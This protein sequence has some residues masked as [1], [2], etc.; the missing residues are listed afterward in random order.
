MEKINIS[1][2]LK[3]CPTGMELDCTI[4]DNVYFDE[5][6]PHMIKCFVKNDAY[7][8]I[9]FHHDGTYFPAQSAKCVIFPKGKTT[10][11]GF[12]RPFK[13]GDVLIKD[14]NA[15][16]I[17]K[18]IHKTYKNKSFIDFYCGYRPSD[19]QLVIKKFGDTHFGFI[20][21]AK[22]A[23]E[24]EKQKLFD[25][26]KANGY[27]WNAE[28]KTLEKLIE[29]KFKVGDII[30]DKDGYKVKVT[31][32]S[33]EDECYEY[34]S[35]IT[36][37]IGGIGFNEQEIWELVHN[38]FDITTLKPFE[39]KVLVRA[40]NGKWIAAFYSHYDNDSSLHYCVV[41]GLWYAQCIPYKG[42]EYLLN[43]T[44]DCSEY[45]KTWE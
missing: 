31:N 21:E 42:N 19:N 38:K 43:T 22:L 5:V 13:D 45:Y 7:N 32:I 8:T 26:I 39:S 12:Q 25:A 41:G 15:L 1:E 10:W 9:Y 17:Y 16:C 27:R 11:E 28:T 44:N 29:P 33:I 14:N 23:T 37:G 30:Q 3:D 2:L 34:E 24:E 35:I 20:S 36:K 6:T 18:S 40:N 4:C